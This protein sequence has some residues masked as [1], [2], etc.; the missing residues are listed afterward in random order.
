MKPDA[1]LP[2]PGVRGGLGLLRPVEHKDG[3]SCPISVCGSYGGLARRPVGISAPPS[4]AHSCS[5]WSWGVRDH[6]RE[7]AAMLHFVF[8]PSSTELFQY[9]NNQ[10]FWSI[11]PKYHLTLAQWQQHSL[12]FMHTKNIY[13]HKHTS[14]PLAR[15]DQD[16]PQRILWGFTYYIHI[17][18]RIFMLMYVSL[19]RNMDLF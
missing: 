7:L 19:T 3:T 14:V 9:F 1:L 6:L 12:S 18:M 10:F 2:P 8:L 11:P 16:P 5:P 4:S 15:A 17:S 13:T